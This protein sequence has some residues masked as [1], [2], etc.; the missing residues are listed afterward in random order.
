MTESCKTEKQTESVK[1]KT[2]Y[3]A[4]ISKLQQEKPSATGSC[5]GSSILE[6]ENAKLK[7]KIEVMD[8]VLKK[9]C[10]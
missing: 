9:K 4:Q 7:K 10:G 5:Q 1:C 3:E 8:K 6:E 2:Y